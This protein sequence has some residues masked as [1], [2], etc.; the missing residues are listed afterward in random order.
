M[1]GAA[2]PASGAGGTASEQPAPRLGR[3]RDH[4]RDAEILEATL[5]LLAETGY[6]AMSDTELSPDRLPD[7]GSLRGDMI[8]MINPHWLGASEHRSKILSSLMSLLYRAPELASAV[9]AAIVEPSAAAYR[10]LMARAA[11]RGEIPASTDI[12][13]LA[14][15]IPSMSAYRVMFMRGCADRA[16]HEAL[17]DEVVLPALGVRTSRSATDQRF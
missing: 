16:F 15:I 10:Q 2:A 9:D 8:A 17:V 7:T 3:K 1:S 13:A 14:L 4:T 12:D 5:D 11:E 6:E